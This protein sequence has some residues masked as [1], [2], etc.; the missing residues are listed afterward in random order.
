MRSE[1]PTGVPLSPSPP[2]YLSIALALV[3]LV[4]LWLFSRGAIVGTLATLEQVTGSIS[5]DEFMWATPSLVLRDLPASAATEA[6]T[7]VGRAPHDQ[8][9]TI[10][11]GTWLRMTVNV[12]AGY[13]RQ[14]LPSSRV[15]QQSGITVTSNW[16]LIP[17]ATTG[18]RDMRALSY[19]LYEVR[20]GAISL[21]LAEIATS[22]N[23]LY[24]V[25]KID[26]RND[27]QGTL[28]GK[29]DAAWY[30]SIATNGY[31]FDGD[32]WRQQNVAWPF[33]YPVLVKALSAATKMPIS[34]AM[35]ALNAGL[36]LGSLFLLFLLGMEMQLSVPAAMIAPAWVA[37]NPFAYFLFGGFSEALFLILECAFVLLLIHKRYGLAVCV[38]ALLGATRF[39]GYIAIV[40]LLL[41]L[42]RPEALQGRSRWPKIIAIAGTGLLGVAADIGVKWYQTGYPHAAFAVRSAWVVTGSD[43]WANVFQVQR[44]AQGEYEPL[45]LLSFA[46]LGYCILVGLDAL[47]HGTRDPNVQVTA[48]ATFVVAATLSLNPELH[49]VG[50]YMLPL[51]PALVGAL[52]APRWHPKTIV[53]LPMITILGAI[54][55]PLVVTRIANGLPPY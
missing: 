40:W 3:G 53:L 30:K 5:A 45:L 1:R 10:E 35:L 16:S 49:S 54:Y 31:R 26:L 17:G 51:A 19:Q 18:S 12:S 55:L 47:K 32:R 44:L 29:W 36:V 43:Q 21:P 4:L 20:V 13:F 34:R 2:R 33:L 27:A 15:C 41:A 50:R 9:W 22:A 48:V 37:C 38:V 23:G 52:A 11:C 25:E 42:W 14:S 8:N 7:L 46:T 39:I 28:T 24:G 6:V